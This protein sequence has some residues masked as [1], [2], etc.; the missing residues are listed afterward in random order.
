MKKCERGLIGQLAQAVVLSAAV[1]DYTS[2]VTRESKQWKAKMTTGKLL[3]SAGTSASGTDSG[4]QVVAIG[5]FDVM[6]EACDEVWCLLTIEEEGLMLTKHGETWKRVGW[7][8]LEEKKW[9][10]GRSTAAFNLI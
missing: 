7:F 8:G 6:R 3:V 9:V 10:E 4:E 5:F 1:K 2:K